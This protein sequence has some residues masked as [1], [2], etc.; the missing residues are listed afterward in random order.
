LEEKWK[1]RKQVW[2]ETCVLVMGIRK[3]QEKEWISSSTFEKI[4]KRKS[5]KEAC[6]NTKTRAAKQAAADK[7][8]EHIKKSKGAQDATNASISTDW[9][10]KPRKRQ[11]NNICMNYMPTQENLQ[12]KQSQ[13]L[14]LCIATMESL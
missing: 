10:W 12:E 4:E 6:N 3:Q 13:H 14:V 2:L 9:P 7:F 1:D 11:G 5:L 8:R